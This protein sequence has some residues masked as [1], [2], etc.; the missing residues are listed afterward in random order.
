MVSCR[1]ACRTCADAAPLPVT[2]WSLR[3]RR[4]ELSAGPLLM[5]IVN[6]TPDSFSDGGAFLAPNAAVD[7]A[8]ALVEQGADILDVGGE[9][10]RPYSVPVSERE[11][12]KRLEPVLARLAAHTQVPLS[13]DTSKPRVAAMALGY[14]RKSSTISPAWLSSRWYTW[15]PSRNAACVRCTFAGPRRICRTI[16]AITTWSVRSLLTSRRGGIGW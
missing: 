12:L 10:T 15:P 6:V 1:H 5:G 9:S 16:P 8:L 4:L 14:A 13:I 7:H 2:S 3:T 11:E